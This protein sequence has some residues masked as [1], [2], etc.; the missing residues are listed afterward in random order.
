MTA[1]IGEFKGHKT[2]TLAEEGENAK[3]PFSFGLS[4]AILEDLN[5]L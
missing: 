3:F 5:L 1:T 2:L 4:K